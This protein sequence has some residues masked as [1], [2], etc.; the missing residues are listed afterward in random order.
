M[1]ADHPVR[2]VSE[3]WSAVV[4]RSGA[5]IIG[6]DIGPSGDFTLQRTLDLDTSFADEC[7]G[8]CGV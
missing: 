1:G 5:T 8:V 3:A 7:S 4:L 2:L 6:R